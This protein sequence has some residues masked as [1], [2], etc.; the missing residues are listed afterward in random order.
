MKTKHIFLFILFIL[1]NNCIKADIKT[2]NPF[3]RQELSLKEKKA[4]VKTSLRKIVIQKL[5]ISGN[6]YIA[7]RVI[8]T[9]LNLKEKNLIPAERELLENR[10]NSSIKNLINTGYFLNAS[11]S[12][13]DI[14]KDG[15]YINIKVVE[16]PIIKKIEILGDKVIS[17]EEILSVMKTR[18]NEILNVNVF[19]KDVTRIRN[20]YAKNG[21]SIDASSNISLDKTWTKI[22]VDTYAM[23]VNKIITEG[24]HKTKNYVIKRE[25]LFKNNELYTVKKMRRSY[26]NLLNLGFFKNV[27][28]YNKPAKKKGSSS[29]VVKVEE[30]D[31]GTLRF[32]GT[33]GSKNG[34]SGLFDLSENNFRGKGQRLN[35][36]LELGGVRNY[37][38]GFNEPWIY[39]KPISMGFNL[40]F[41][42]NNKKRYD[43]DGNFL[44]DY[45]EKRKGGSLSFTRRFNLFLSSTIRFKDEHI[46]ID[47]E[48]DDM[49]NDRI[50]SILYGISRDTRNN[51][52]APSFGT[53]NSI[54]FETTGGFLAG[55]NDYTR[56]STDSRHFYPFSKSGKDVVG[57]RFKLGNIDLRKGDLTV[58]DK[59][60][61][62]GG[63][64]LRGFN[65]WEFT[66]KQMLLYNLEFVHR[67]SKNFSFVLFNDLGTAVHEL[68]YKTN[69]HN[70]IGGGVRFKTPM[71]LI[72]FEYGQATTEDRNG[73][74]YF[75]FGQMF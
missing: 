66:G 25:I 37:E 36:K 73:K 42:Q 74:T 67:F 60:K 62:G 57:W 69:F 33:Y 27:E 70:G 53:Y 21:Y 20:L 1:F 50:Q 12:K 22:I 72:R 2:K 54:S 58:Y 65:D 68:T 19:K 64:T 38:I 71:G 55:K 9:A 63:N 40:Y 30:D 6:K 15:L 61:V 4:K 44:Y 34:L 18:I 16:N 45:T 10:I 31:T 48:T 52:F 13:F 28:I 29:L 59:F 5:E 75:N 49:N 14:E 56:T 23:R 47:P 8:R 46:T 11:I 3:K 32:G 26:R 7:D 51:K 43:D 35:L 17:D 39:N 24:N 41:N